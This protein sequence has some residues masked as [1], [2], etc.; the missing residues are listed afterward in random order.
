MVSTHLWK[1][2]WSNWIISPTRGAKTFESTGFLDNLNPRI[3]E[4]PTNWFTTEQAM[5]KTYSNSSIQ[6][7]RIHPVF[8]F[9]R[10]LPSL[11]LTVFSTWEFWNRAWCH[12]SA[13][14]QLLQLCLSPANKARVERCCFHLQGIV[15]EIEV[16]WCQVAKVGPLCVLVPGDNWRLKS[17]HPEH[18]D[19]C[20]E[21]HA[22][23]GGGRS[24][25]ARLHMEVDPLP[26]GR[27]SW[28]RPATWWWSIKK[29]ATC[30]SSERVQYIN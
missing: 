12:R 4:T 22:V 6:D 17:S 23:C 15:E 5:N 21:L 13:A 8:S 10:E 30:S 25:P 3:F 26:G 16:L 18:F 11:K 27:A 14:V 9:F 28:A 1:T 2:C 24:L 7:P 29:P 20:S 19:G